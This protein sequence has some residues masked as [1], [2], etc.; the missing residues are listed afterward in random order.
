MQERPVDLY[1]IEFDQAQ[2]G[3]AGKAR[4]EVIQPYPD[5][6]RFE[7]ADAAQDARMHLHFEPFGD[8]E[9]KTAAGHAGLSEDRGDRGCKARSL[10][11]DR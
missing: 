10:Q 4:A 8:L 1:G 5:A 7:V 3:E 2:P 9:G 6:Q 11:L